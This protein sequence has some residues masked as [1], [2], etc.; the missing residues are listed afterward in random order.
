VF[1]STDDAPKVRV[2]DSLGRAVAIDARHAMSADPAYVC[3]DDDTYDVVAWAGP[4]PVEERWWDARRARRAVRLQLLVR[5]RH[6]ERS[7]TSKTDA[8][9]SRAM[10]A[11]LERRT[12]RLAAIYA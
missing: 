11:V 3:I 8:S 1:D 5:Q 4:W 9:A 6:G 2:L 12:W 10:V 7:D